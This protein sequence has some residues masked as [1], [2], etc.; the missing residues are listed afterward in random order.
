MKIACPPLLLVSHQITFH[1]RGSC[2]GIRSIVGMFIKKQTTP[3]GWS[4]F[5]PSC[6]WL[7]LCVLIIFAA[8]QDIMKFHLAQRPLRLDVGCRVPAA[9]FSKPLTHG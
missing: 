1:R 4:D 9:I 7:I 5:A 8:L 3:G 6:E 2:G